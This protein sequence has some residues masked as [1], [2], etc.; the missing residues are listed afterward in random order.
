[1]GSILECCLIY[2]IDKGNSS[3]PFAGREAS[4]TERISNHNK[5]DQH[6]KYKIFFTAYCSHNGSLFFQSHN[7][8]GRT[9]GTSTL[10][11]YTCLTQKKAAHSEQP[12]T[13]M[14]E[15]LI[16]FYKSNCFTTCSLNNFDK[17]ITPFI[18]TSEYYR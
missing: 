1:M 12:Y 11:C 10:S 2:L 9:F 15:L 6:L 7:P 5:L 8:C 4:Y 16:Q 13:Y 14:V 3:E 17:V 18:I